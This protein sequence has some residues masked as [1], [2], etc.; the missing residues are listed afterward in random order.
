MKEEGQNILFIKIIR[1]LFLFQMSH[2]IDIGIAFISVIILSVSFLLMVILLSIVFIT[3]FTEEQILI[4]TNEED[5]SVAYTEANEL[6]ENTAKGQFD[7]E[8]ISYIS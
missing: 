5:I 7:E 6:E 3:L 2:Q 8:T 4:S 1:H